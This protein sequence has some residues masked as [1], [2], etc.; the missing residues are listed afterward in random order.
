MS[1]NKNTEYRYEDTNNNF[2]NTIEEIIGCDE[3]VVALYDNISSGIA[4]VSREGRIYCSNN[5]LSF[6]TG[7]SGDELKEINFPS[8][9][10]GKDSARVKEILSLSFSGCNPNTH[11]EV[12][13]FK[14]DGTRSWVDMSASSSW[15][16]PDERDYCYVFINDVSAEKKYKDS[17]KNSL[18]K[19]NLLGN[20]AKN[21]GI[22]R[23]SAINCYLDLAGEKIDPGTRQ[24]CSVVAGHM[25]TIGKF[26]EFAAWMYDCTL[27][28]PEWQ[29]LS[30]VFEK[31]REFDGRIPIDY[32][33]RF[34]KIEI[35]SDHSLVNVF[36]KLFEFSIKYGQVTTKVSV[37]LVESESGSFT[38]IWKDNG[39][40]LN[41]EIRAKVFDKGRV[42]G[43]GFGLLLVKEVLSFSG[44]KITEKG[45][46]GEGALFEITFP[47][48]NWRHSG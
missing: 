3:K 44:A 25:D 48:E 21:D 35:L 5:F 6:I 39:L 10:C 24:Y 22:N 41:P 43:P 28:Q 36:E 19:I 9:F 16:G 4:V 32:N 12:S 17:S 38:I 15:K 18:R 13:F 33:I 14:K 46:D 1:E 27:F 40:G 34:N 29:L 42:A 30:D 20:Y 26:M 2:F 47:S 37:D 7:Y 31:V 23:V 11:F 8:F 45:T